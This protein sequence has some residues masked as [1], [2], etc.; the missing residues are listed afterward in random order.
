MDETT[1]TKGRIRKLN[2]LRRLVGDK[3]GEEAFSKWLA[4]QKKAS[5]ARRADPVA[6]K[7]VEALAGDAGDRNFRLG[8]YGYTVKRAR[9]KGVS[10]FVAVKNTKKP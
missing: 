6:E 2:A 8:N 5:A 4:Q 10:G 1:L 3:L 9:G 7:I